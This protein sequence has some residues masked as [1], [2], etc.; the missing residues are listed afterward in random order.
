LKRT[1][2]LHD[3]A[4]SPQPCRPPAP[5][6]GNH[7]AHRDPGLPGAQHGRARR[8]PAEP[9]AEIP[10]HAAEGL[11]MTSENIC[12]AKFATKP[13]Y[14]AIELTHIIYDP[15]ARNG[16]WCCAPYTGHPHG[17]PNFIKGCTTKRPPFSELIPRYEKWFAI[18]ET[19]D[20]KSH[21]EE[22]KLKHPHWSSR[23]C[24]NPLYWQG[25][26]RAN[27][28][29]RSERFN[30]YL[31]F[32]YGRRGYILDIPEA[33]GIDVFETMAQVGITLERVPETV[34]KIMI[35]GLP[36]IP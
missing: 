9:G 4:P 8:A 3:P 5:V 18:I 1:G 24:R 12:S 29:R 28:K 20:L 11:A 10:V 34:R 6:P 15:S 27:L 36:A 25:T 19:F 23:Q 31:E 21:A 16:K 17:C 30:D 2:G 32:F 33:N 14:D 35:V 13:N 26:V 7:R 22:K